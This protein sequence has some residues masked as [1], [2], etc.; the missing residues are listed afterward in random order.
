MVLM[1]INGSL[2]R[3]IKLRHARQRITPLAVY[4]QRMLI[5]SG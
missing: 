1:S 4:K 5:N 2:G 3:G